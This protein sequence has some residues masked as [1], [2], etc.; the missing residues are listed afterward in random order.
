[1]GFLSDARLALTVAWTSGVESPWGSPHPHHLGSVVWSDIFG[2]DE[3]LPPTRAAAMRVP[4]MARARNLICGTIAQLPLTARRDGADVTSQHAWLTRTDRDVSMMH[5]MLWTCD[6]LLFGGWALWQVDRLADGSVAQVWRIHPDRWTIDATGSLEIDSRPVPPGM[7]DRLCLIPGVNEGILA[8]A[9]EALR[10]SADLSAAAGRAAYA[11]SPTM[12][13]HYT[14]KTELSEDR[15]DAIIARW[16]A[17]RRGKNG[18]VAWTN[19]VIE[20]KE[21]G[22]SSEHL[23]IEGRNAAA[24]DIARHASIPAA[25]IDAASGDSLTYKTT[26]GKITELIDFGCAPLMAAISARLSL[27]DMTPRGTT[28]AFDRED[29]VGAQRQAAADESTEARPRLRP[30]EEAS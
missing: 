14:G 20:T 26:E 11:P 25:M 23:L 16:A 29:L 6:D 17:A 21:H 4:A 5:T 24:V 8:T 12:E 15:I 7:S 3:H 10:Q 30:V 18:G 22:S 1:M 13:L 28:V 2:S 9:A 27:D 19:S